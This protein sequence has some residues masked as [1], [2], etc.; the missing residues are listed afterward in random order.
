MTNEWILGCHFIRGRLMS[1][2]SVP[3]SKLTGRIHA[4]SWC[5]Y[6]C[7][8]ARLLLFPGFLKGK[9]WI[10]DTRFSACLY[11]L[12]NS[13]IITFRE[14]F[15]CW[16][17]HYWQQALFGA[18]TLS[19]RYI[20]ITFVIFIVL[21]I[22]ELIL[23]TIWTSIFVYIMFKAIL[24]RQYHLYLNYIRV[25]LVIW[26]L[27]HL[28]S[29]SSVLLFHYLPFWKKSYIYIFVYIIITLHGST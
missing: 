9:I 2:L 3:R 28:V 26:I 10:S 15:T 1:P 25:D 19:Q 29:W 21:V 6:M 18:S 4:A 11:I 22:V 17:P 16:I 12:L 20:T 8:A 13:V 14:T 5:L 23:G 7:W 27:W 24:C